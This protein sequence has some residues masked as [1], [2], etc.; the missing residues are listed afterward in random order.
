[1]DKNTGLYI[2]LGFL[3]LCI[4]LS[5][6]KK[7]GFIEINLREL[8]YLC[9]VNDDISSCNINY[10]GE[11]G[12]FCNDPIDYNMYSINSSTK[13]T[14]SENFNIEFNENTSYP[15]L[16]GCRPGY[17]RADPQIRPTVIPCSSSG[18]DYILNGCIEQCTP[19]EIP[20]D[21]YGYIGGNDSL[22]NIQYGSVIDLSEVLECPGQISSLNKCYNIRGVSLT[23]SDESSCS[24]QGGIWYGNSGGPIRGVC[25][26]Y[27]GEQATY[28]IIGCEEKRCLSR[29]INPDYYISDDLADNKEKIYIKNAEDIIISDTPLNYTDINYNLT[30]GNLNPF[31]FN[32]DVTCDIFS[33]PTNVF[34][35]NTF[36]G[37]P[38]IETCPINNNGLPLDEREKY[39][40]YGCFPDCGS[41]VECVNISLEYREGQSAPDITDYKFQL[42]QIYMPIVSSEDEDAMERALKASE[43][44]E[45]LYFFRKYRHDGRDYIEAQLRCN[46]NDGSDGGSMCNLINTNDLGETPCGVADVS[47]TDS[48]TPRQYIN[49]CYSINTTISDTSG[50]TSIDDLNLNCDYYYQTVGGDNKICSLQTTSEGA[51]V[52]IN[53]GGINYGED[54][55]EG[56]FFQ[57]AASENSCP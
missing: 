47:G 15:E 35:R 22:T 42:Q 54:E 34:L 4:L 38:R 39:R 52:G 32:V 11:S 33:S 17:Q 10:S 26:N 24:S 44:L 8:N 31:N 53:I 30:E 55:L 36:S 23:A 21:I 18:E 40:V 12:H 51:L 19:P 5:L 56:K 16:S 46:R 27:N 28:N 41:D 13:N 20:N 25:D 43:L 50:I 29:N 6:D 7:E 37:T 45:S 2:V 9:N 49:N 1:M 57:C 48:V 3:L 14:F